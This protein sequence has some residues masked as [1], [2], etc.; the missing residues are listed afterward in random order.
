MSRNP[1]MLLAALLLA[2]NLASTP[3]LPHDG[4]ASTAYLIYTTQAGDS[5]AALANRFGVPRMAILW[6]DRPPEAAG[7]AWREITQ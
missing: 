4:D 3:Q 7:T 1:S 6:S 5:L 2:A